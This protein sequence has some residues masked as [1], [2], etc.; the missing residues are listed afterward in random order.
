VTTKR[1][2]RLTTYIAVL[3]MVFFRFLPV[4]MYIEKKRDNKIAIFFL[5]FIC[6]Y[7]NRMNKLCMKQRIKL[8]RGIFMIK[9]LLSLSPPLSFTAVVALSSLLSV[10]AIPSFLFLILSLAFALRNTHA[11]ADKE[12]RNETQIT[13]HHCH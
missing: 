10:L 8:K 11:T 4:E 12:K 1:V 13:K 2:E 5:C 9:T 3:I 7:L 6:V